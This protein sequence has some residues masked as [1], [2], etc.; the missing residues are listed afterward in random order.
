MSPEPTSGHFHDPW[1]Y[2]RPQLAQSYLWGFD[3]G[4]A[5]ALTLFAERGSGKTSFLKYDLAP[6]A[7]AAGLQPVLIDFESNRIDPGPVIA[8]AFEAAARALRRADYKPNVLGSIGEKAARLPT[9]VTSHPMDSDILSRIGFWGAQMVSCSR[10]PIV[11]IMDEVQALAAGPSTSHVAWALRAVL[12]RFGRLDVRPIFTC[13]SREGLG[14]VFNRTSAAFFQYGSIWDLPPLDDGFVPF[15]AERLHDSARDTNLKKLL[16]AYEAL[17][18]R[19]GPIRRLV[20][21]MSRERSADVDKFLQR[22][23]GLERGIASSTVA[24]DRLKPLERAILKYVAAAGVV[25]TAE[26]KRYFAD[27]LGVGVVNPKSIRTAVDRLRREG[28]LSWVSR[29]RYRVENPDMAG[30]LASAASANAGRPDRNPTS[31]P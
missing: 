27:H 20:E 12:Q 23:V 11:L 22:Q 7:V 19:P 18:Q 3:P 30:I 25:Y 16:S 5:E 4:P 6:A 8:D 15:L 14:N 26:A 28:L 29:G 2:P 17:G 24:L 21:T 31:P 1:H 9:R 10:N 13:S